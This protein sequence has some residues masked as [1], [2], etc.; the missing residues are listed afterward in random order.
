VGARRWL[1]VRSVSSAPAHEMAQPSK[2]DW[3]Q[4]DHARR[5]S[6]RSLVTRPISKST[7]S[8][9]WRPLEFYPT[10][11][12][13][14]FGKRHQHSLRHDLDTFSRPSQRIRRRS[15]VYHAPAY[16]RFPIRSDPFP[17]LLGSPTYVLLDYRLP[18]WCFTNWSCDSIA[19]WKVISILVRTLDFNGNRSFLI[20][21]LENNVV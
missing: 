6:R 2:F 1:T 8:D 19:S 3:V 11:L 20:G 10:K 18:L 14:P 4:R 5:H 17:G 13:T 15:P 12:S 7:L 9:C 21:I 16:R